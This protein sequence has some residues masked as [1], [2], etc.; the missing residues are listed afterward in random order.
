MRGGVVGRQSFAD[1]SS[2]RP[3]ATCYSR[4]QLLPSHA[5]AARRSP[6]AAHPLLQRRLLSLSRHKE[7]N[8]RKGVRASPS[9]REFLGSSRCTSLNYFWRLFSVVLK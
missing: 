9:I 1:V 8:Q 4:E 7:S 2:V 5:A 6:H 3:P